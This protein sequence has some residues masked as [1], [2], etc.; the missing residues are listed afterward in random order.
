M[1]APIRGHFGHEAMSELPSATFAQA[2][3]MA[4]SVVA[5]CCS[6]LSAISARRPSAS[7]NSPSLSQARACCR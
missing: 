6:V 7:C 1:Q 2:L 4:L 3:I 5:F